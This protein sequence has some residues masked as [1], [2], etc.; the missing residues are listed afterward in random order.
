MP[1]LGLIGRPAE[2]AKHCVLT[3]I[4]GDHIHLSLDISGENLFAKTAEQ[5]IEAALKTY[6]NK[7]VHLHI[8]TQRLTEET[9]A[10]R[11]GR[12][13]QERQ[14]AAEDLMQ[15]DPFVQELQSRFNAQLVPNSVKPK[16][17]SH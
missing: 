14:K 13:Q 12:K 16:E 5:E 7:P 9:P 11:I 2:L 17:N 6:Y 15:N 8:N 4:E 3:S 10:E 1:K